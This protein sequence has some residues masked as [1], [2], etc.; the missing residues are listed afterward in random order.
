MRERNRETLGR[1]LRDLAKA[2]DP[3]A[4]LLEYARY[5]VPHDAQST[6]EVTDA[7][8]RKGI[9]DAV[10]ASAAALLQG[11]SRVESEAAVARAC[12][13]LQQLLG[14]R[15]AAG[16]EDLEADIGGLY[17]TSAISLFALND[18]LRE[19]AYPPA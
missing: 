19:A 11:T 2:A 16:E 14:V 17:D 10:K 13:R 3:A 18:R 7:R 8:R 12:R 6:L 5:E 9:E 1:L 4:T 15:A